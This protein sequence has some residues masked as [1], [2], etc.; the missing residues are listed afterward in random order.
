MTAKGYMAK[1]NEIR[2]QMLQ[3]TY[4][5]IQDEKASVRITFNGATTHPHLRTVSRVLRV[6]G[7]P[8][9]LRKL[10]MKLFYEETN[11]SV[12]HRLQSRVICSSDPFIT[13]GG[14]SFCEGRGRGHGKGTR[15]FFEKDL[16]KEVAEI[17]KKKSRRG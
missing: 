16:L 14:S 17:E 10:G 4:R 3:F 1:Q 13:R 8:E 11:H 5:N 9:T 6:G 15:S 12:E 2:L 7:I